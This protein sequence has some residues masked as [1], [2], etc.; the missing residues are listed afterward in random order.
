MG[1]KTATKSAFFYGT[2]MHP[3]VLKTVIGNDGKHLK[4]CPAVLRDYTRHKIFNEEYPAILPYEKGGKLFDRELELEER[5][6]RGTL[7]IGLTSANI[8]KLDVFEG[9]EYIRQT[10]LVHPLEEATPLNDFAG[11]DKNLIERIAPAEPQPIDEVLAKASSDC[12]EAEVYVFQEDVSKL[13][14]ALWSFGEFVRKN[15]W[16][17]YGGQVSRG[18]KSTARQL[19]NNETPYSLVPPVMPSRLLAACAALA[20]LF[21]LYVLSNAMLNGSYLD[22]DELPDI[23][24]YRHLQVLSKEEF[25]TDNPS[26]RVIIVGD[27]HGEHRHLQNLLTRLF[28]DNKT[29]TL[30]FL[31]DIIT[32]GPH[33]GSLDVLSYFSSNN[34]QGVRGNQ[35]QKVIEWRSW[36]NWV[37]SQPGGKHFLGSTRDDWHKAKK[38][39]ERLK[40]WNVRQREL[41]SG[42]SPKSGEGCM[43]AITAKWWHRVP[44]GWVLFSDDF[45]LASDMSERDYEYLASRP[46]RIYVPHT[47][48]FL[49]HAGLLSH[50]PRYGYDDPSQPLVQ[51]VN[52]SRIYAYY[53]GLDHLRAIMKP[54]TGWLAW[55]I[56]QGRGRDEEDDDSDVYRDL[57]RERQE[58]AILAMPINMDPWVS[59]NIRGVKNGRPI[60]DKK[61]IPWSEIW[62]A[63]MNLCEGFDDDD[64]PRDDIHVTTGDINKRRMLPCLPMSVVYGHAAARGLDI[65]RW[66]FGLDTGC[67]Y[68]DHLSA[69]VLGRIDDLWDGDDEDHNNN[70]PRPVPFGDS[71][72]ARVVSVSCKHES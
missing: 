63:D 47:H 9:N 3:K 19:Y 23:S 35:D 53:N 28:Y 15:A 33:Q 30:F 11:Q 21:L 6:V 59:L 58:R 31:G 4:I 62:N 67:V 5:C 29:D 38:N 44:E 10:V 56:L 36:I 46:V 14:P 70:Y 42:K 54:L 24:R 39:G 37:V 7:V 18:S 34:I 55:P 65:K 66:S 48:S 2:L 71:D 40:K 32:K 22:K 26:K 52:P 49:V 17:W 45:M 51:T 12:A 1:R 25:P 41:A 13:E 43:D 57:R 50:D 20:S 60:R 27:I 68:G 64:D 16:K 69:L 61:G 72:Q 8:R